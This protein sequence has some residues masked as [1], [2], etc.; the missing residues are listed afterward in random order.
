MCALKVA[1]EG[2]LQRLWELPRC[3]WSQ[4]CFVASNTVLIK[5]K[6]PS[7]KNKKSFILLMF[8]LK[9]YFWIPYNNNNSNKSLFLKPDDILFFTSQPCV[10]WTVCQDASRHHEI[11]KADYW[12]H[13][14]TMNHR[15][16]RGMFIHF[17]DWYWLFH[18]NNPLVP[19]AERF[20]G[21]FSV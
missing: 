6:C 13:D 11:L 10:Q 21:I 19:W 3:C 17:Y 1:W 16:E 7:V 12:E 20:C 14:L 9:T 18:A 2:Q 4:L 15:D 5:Q 8:M